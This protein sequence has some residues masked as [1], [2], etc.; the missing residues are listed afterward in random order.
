MPVTT[1]LFCGIAVVLLTLGYRVNRSKRKLAEG[2]GWAVASS[3]ILAYLEVGRS[4][5]A[6]WGAVL[7]AAMAVAVLSVAITFARRLL[8]SLDS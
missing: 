4:W 3:V 8:R 2:A 7:T 1:I 5:D 6:P